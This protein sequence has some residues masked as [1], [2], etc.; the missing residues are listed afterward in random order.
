MHTFSLL[1]R[2]VFL[3]YHQHYQRHTVLAVAGEVIGM[4]GGFASAGAVTV[5]TMKSWVCATR[6]AMVG[7][8]TGQGAGRNAPPSPLH[9]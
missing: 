7:E 1:Y 5:M 8:M 2:D 9:L 3:T 6:A 4:T